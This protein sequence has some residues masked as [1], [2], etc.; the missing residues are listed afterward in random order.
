MTLVLSTDDVNKVLSM[1]ECIEVMKATFKDFYS[2]RA[3]N[4]PRIRYTAESPLEGA[5]YA[6]NVHVGAVPGCGVAAVRVGSYLR[7]AET[8][9]ERREKYRQVGARSTSL[10]FL[11]SLETSELI[12]ILPEHSID[13]RVGATTAVAACQLAKPGAH[14]L[15]LF[16]SGNQA[17]M[18]L[19]A[20]LLA[21]PAIDEVRVFSPNPEHLQAFAADV[22][23]R[24]GR[25]VLTVSE[26]RE[27][28]K[29][30][31]IVTCATNSSRPVFPGEWIEPGQL[32]TTI[33]SSDVVDM[34]TE[35]DETTIARAEMIYVNDIAAIGANQQ[36]ELLDPLDQGKISWEG[37]H[38]LGEVLHGK[39][40]RRRDD[41][42]IYYKNNSGMGIQF[43]ALGGL[44]YRRALS[45]N[46]GR[47][48]PTAWLAPA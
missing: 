7:A 43:A 22:K 14:R 13:G 9:A 48:V 16:G 17:R 36:H 33:V 42:V 38:E 29:G 18:N 27:V 19:E 41:E 28:V 44:V 26:P 39:Y 46:L 30:A 45:A 25:S 10:V 31:D 1:P 34:R 24:L 47:Q 4:R 15:G 40:G 20:L 3:V 23:R 8:N 5:K 37:V 12:C 21:I 35:V 6:T 11:Y 2:G 32:V